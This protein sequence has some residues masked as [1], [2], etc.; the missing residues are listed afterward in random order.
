MT[1]ASTASNDRQPAG[2]AIEAL[3]AS[4]ARRGKLLVIGA[5]VLDRIFYVESLPRAGETAVG[6]RMDI[7]PGGKGAN[8]ALAAAKMGAEVRF[9]SAV[10]ADPEAEIVLEPLRAANVDVEP[11]YH[12]EGERTAETVISVDNRGEN[13]IVACPNA[14]HRIEQKHIEQRTD[15][16]QWADWLLVQNELPRGVVD[17]AISMGIEAGVKVVFNTAPFKLHAPPPPRGIEV[18][19]ANE[20]EAAGILGE[21]DYLSIDP[22]KRA[23][24]WREIGAANVLITLGRNGGEWFDTKGKRHE[25]AASSSGPVVDTVGAGDALCGIFCAL[26]AEGLSIER[27]ASIA[28]LGAGIAITREGAQG[29]LPTR[30]ELAG[31]ARQSL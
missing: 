13:Q 3:S 12:I 15:L 7:F 22:H 8:Q 17:R 4:P 20:I 30:E 14:Y 21:Q 27:A 29:G 23:S 9:L 19:I 26:A 11:V 5:A 1:V 16:F 28:H 25:F 18:L 2:I 24:H 6:D 31:A 10:G